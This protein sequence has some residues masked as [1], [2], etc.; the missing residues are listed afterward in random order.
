MRARPQPLPRPAAASRWLLA[1][2]GWPVVAAAQTSP[3][4]LTVSQAVQHDSNMLRLY[5]S[6][7]P[8]SGLVRS[9]TLYTTGL[10]VKLDQPISRQRLFGQATVQ[11]LRYQR[12]D[13]YNDLAYSAQLGLDWSTVNRL[14]GNLTASANRAQRPTLRDRSDGL[15][16]TDNPEETRALDARIALGVA[17]RMTLE[18]VY[19]YRSLAYSSAASRFR[20]YS[21]HSVLTGLRYQFSSALDTGINLRRTRIS[22]PL[23]LLG[24]PDPADVRTRDELALQ[25]RWQPGGSSTLSARLAYSRTQHE[26]L[27]ARDFNAATGGLE[28]LWN[29]GGR[30]QFETRYGRDAGQDD[31]INTSV[32]SRTTDTL[33][34]KGRYH[35]GGKTWL[36]AG[37]TWYRRSQQG[38]GGG[39]DGVEGRD[40]GVSYMLGATWA[41]TRSVTLGCDLNRER[42]GTN[43]SPLINESFNA[44]S[45]GCSGQL[46]LQ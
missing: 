1:L 45:V 9:D 38:H 25:A 6:Q 36:N 44:S 21:Q 37:L 13:V 41:P 27:A 4:A 12:N 24:L 2:A 5:G 15:I 19:G 34:L 22:Y 17:T 16:A 29:P 31:N 43:S 40:T 35:L 3:Y 26:Q 10:Q 28:W 14:S 18:A 7:L 33:A 39:L 42:R 8:P 20:N 30:W 32:F 46:T 11:A 23:L